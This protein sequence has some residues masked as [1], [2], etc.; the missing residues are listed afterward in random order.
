MKLCVIFTKI[1]LTF[2]F[3]KNTQCD[4]LRQKKNNSHASGL[5]KKFGRHY[6]SIIVATHY[7]IITGNCP[8][9]CFPALPFVR[10]FVIHNRLFQNLLVHY[11]NIVILLSVR[12]SICKLLVPFERSGVDPSSCNSVGHRLL[13]NYIMCLQYQ[14]ISNVKGA[15]YIVYK[16]N[17]RTGAI[18]LLLMCA[19]V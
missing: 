13:T 10:S 8:K 4:H 2:Y 18:V 12:C 3:L 5:K 7:Y 17:N 14:F 19:P 1:C 15:S 6:V 16:K 11:T 9:G